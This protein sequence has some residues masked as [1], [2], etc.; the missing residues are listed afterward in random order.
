MKVSTKVA[1]GSGL[2][3]LLL[4]A[5]LLH[6][7]ALVRRLAAVNRDLS[8][9][10][11]RATTLALDQSRLLDEIGKTAR[12][13]SVTGDPGY[14][15]KLEEQRQALDARFRELATLELEGAGRAEARRLARM[16]EALREA[17]GGAYATDDELAGTDFAEPLAAVQAQA[18]ALLA[19]TQRQVASQVA[20]TTLESETARSV[21]WG[22]LAAAIV[23]ALAVLW[24]TARSIN[25]P[26]KKLAEGTRVV[27]GGEFLYRLEDSQGDEFSSLAESFNEMVRRL[28]ELDETKRDFLSHVS[29]EL[30]TPLVSML[31]T[32]ELLL[33]GIPGPL[34]EEQRRLL[35]L[36]RQSGRRLSAMIS[37]LLDLSRLETQA[38][39]YD[40][41]THDLAELVR[42]AAAE[43]EGRAAE[44]SIELVVAPA[45]PLPV[46]CDRDRMMQVVVNLVDNA[47]K[48]SPAESRVR[49]DVRRAAAP[50][51]TELAPRL[52]R[53][54]ERW[55]GSTL[56]LVEVT[57]AGPGVPEEEKDRIFEKFHQVERARP[58]GGIG[59]GLAI[60]RE[61][62]EAHSGSVWVQDHEERG[63]VF[64]IVLPAALATGGVA[65]AGARG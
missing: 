64:S 25:E 2:L 12:R 46:V 23:L 34:N 63:S 44:C 51:E 7:L 6:D 35:G 28:R 36:N 60:C 41:R 15:A 43:L 18:D 55:P 9:I 19:A 37:K 50:G 17:L 57:D 52:R 65:V 38:L 5:L 27:A 10:S 16:W 40:L 4:A 24:F 29:H 54:A 59:L 20:L 13:L 48:F 22:L 31:E 47:I 30:R 14:A 45:D 8:E 39:E 53:A 42:D 58:G 3:V 1:A 61:I 26:L 56:A 62:V 11:F 33:E 21:S 32:N 49:V